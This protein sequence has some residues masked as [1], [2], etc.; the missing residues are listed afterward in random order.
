MTLEKQPADVDY[1]EFVRHFDVYAPENPLH[2]DAALDHA[3]ARCPISHSVENGGYFLVS[4]YDDVSTVLR[5]ETVEN[6]RFSSR[7]GKSLPAHQTLEMPP[8][9]SDPPEHR[10]FRRLLNKYFSKQ[11]VAKHEPAIT[12]IAHSLIDGFID[13]DNFD[14]LHDFATPLTAATLCAVILGIEDDETMNEALDVVEKIGAANNL[15]PAVWQNL[16]NYLAKLISERTPLGTEN[17]FDAVLAG[18]VNGKPLTDEQKL[19]VI[20]VLFLGGMDTTRA[21]IAFIGHHMVLNPGLEERIR[22]PDWIRSDLDEFL[23]FDSV[24]S[25]MARKVTRSTELHGVELEA[26]D[27]LLIHYYGANHDPETFDRP[28]KLVFDRPRNPHLAFAAGAH[29][30]LGSSLA[31]LEIKVAFAALLDRV[32]NLRLVPGSDI[33]IVPGITRTPRTLPVHFDRRG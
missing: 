7:G 26:E 18:E 10:E 3:R 6:S 17:V 29:R 25:A 8:I 28:H 11:G 12:E 32:E 30:C 21:Q 5:E 27:R 33:S 9:D 1:D 20:T 24:V 23:R 2:L 31:R 22:N 13:K 15:G 4:T 16:N 14:L 19:G